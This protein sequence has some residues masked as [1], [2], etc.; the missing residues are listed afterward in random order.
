[1]LE[2]LGITYISIA[3]RDSLKPFHQ[4]KLTINPLAA[5]GQKAMP[6]GSYELK[7]IVP[8]VYRMM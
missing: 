5:A 2:E 3:H 7:Q 4:L 8:P 1:M 6:E